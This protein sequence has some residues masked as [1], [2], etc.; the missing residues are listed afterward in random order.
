MCTSPRGRRS[1]KADGC[2]A[3]E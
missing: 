1:A 2:P 3:R